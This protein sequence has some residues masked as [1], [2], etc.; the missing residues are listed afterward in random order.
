[1]DYLRMVRFHQEMEATVTLAAIEDP[2]RG[3]PALRDRRGR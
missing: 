3:R 1:M 2:R